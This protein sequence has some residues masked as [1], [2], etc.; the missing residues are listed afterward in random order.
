MT[1]VGV[2]SGEFGSI[3]IN[4][5]FLSSRDLFFRPGCNRIP[6]AWAHPFVASQ[7]VGHLF[8]DFALVATFVEKPAT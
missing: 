6:Q 2:V 4:L 3:F 7:K 5:S 8:A 1:A